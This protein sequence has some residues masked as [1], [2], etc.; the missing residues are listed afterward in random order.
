MRILDADSSQGQCVGL[1]HFSIKRKLLWV[2]HG[3]PLS[4]KN[5]YT[6]Q[7]HKSD[8]LRNP[9]LKGKGLR[10]QDIE[11]SEHNKTETVILFY[12]PSNLN[13]PNLSVPGV[14]FRNG[15]IW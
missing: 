2:F 9:V 12:I 7:I 14:H 15:L 10:S 1:K 3:S 11:M 4:L 13:N 6:N 8:C 5:S